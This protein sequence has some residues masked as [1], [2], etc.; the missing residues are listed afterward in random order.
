[1]RRW[2][3]ELLGGYDSGA[4]S[5]LTATIEEL[6]SKYSRL[7]EWVRETEIET[8]KSGNM[9]ARFLDDALYPECLLSSTW[10]KVLAQMFKPLKLSQLVG[11]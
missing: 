4:V 5:Q 3:I 1:M 9:P 7:E 11:K 2:L 10:N 8:L 6:K